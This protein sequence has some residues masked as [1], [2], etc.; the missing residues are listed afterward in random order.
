MV[1]FVTSGRLDRD[2]VLAITG[3]WL[4]TVLL[5]YWDS[6][7]R[8]LSPRERVGWLLLTLLPFAGAAIY[9]WR[10]T[11]TPVS[12]PRPAGRRVT[13]L[14]PPEPPAP[15]MAT[16][17][18][19][20]AGEAASF[21]PRAESGAELLL[22]AAEGPYRGHHFRVEQLPARIG[23]GGDCAVCLDE[24]PAVSR[25]HAEL[26]RRLDRLWLRDL[27]SKHGVSLNGAT[28]VDQPVEPGDRIKIGN[29]TLILGS[30]R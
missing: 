30:G 20:D 3:L 16:I 29:S 25:Q 12:R 21:S 22:T 9:F 6:G 18:I 27:G 28:V 15:R 4:A 7:R 5:V 13:M 26:Y 19:A 14:R 10:K 8:G 2:V 17:A 11:S 23:R 1:E 24:D